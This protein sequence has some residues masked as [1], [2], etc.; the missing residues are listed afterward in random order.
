MR[1]CMSS[2]PPM[3][4]GVASNAHDLL[5]VHDEPPLFFVQHSNMHRSTSGNRRW[6]PYMN[7][8]Q[9][10]TSHRPR[11][12]SGVLEGAEAWR[13]IVLDYL[14]FVGTTILSWTAWVS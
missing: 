7:H 13:H 14:S 5:R 8:C 1:G 10:A 11:R 9:C 3:P 6:V 4:P 2:G 12:V